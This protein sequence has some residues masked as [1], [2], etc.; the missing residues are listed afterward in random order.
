MLRWTKGGFLSYSLPSRVVFVVCYIRVFWKIPGQSLLWTTTVVHDKETAWVSSMLPCGHFICSHVVTHSIMCLII[1]DSPW[2]MVLQTFL[3][4]Y[5]HYSL[6]SILQWLY[7]FLACVA[8]CVL[9]ILLP[10]LIQ[11]CAQFPEIVSENHASFNAMIFW[12][13]CL[14]VCICLHPCQ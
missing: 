10:M 13:S 12:F 1:T 2:Q 6:Q 5:T 7:N 14:C 3:I 9:K 4:V 11:P 8:V